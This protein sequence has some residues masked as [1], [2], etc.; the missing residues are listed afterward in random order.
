MTRLLICLLLAGCAVP[1][2]AVYYECANGKCA[3]LVEKIGHINVI[4][5][6]GGD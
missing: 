2:R 1:K 5:P 6:R 4:V 3:P